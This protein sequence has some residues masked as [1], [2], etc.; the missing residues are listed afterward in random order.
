MI[1]PADPTL[2]AA[3]P[4]P[5]AV[6]IHPLIAARWSPRA[7]AGRPVER[8]KLQAVFEAARWAPSSFN[9]QPWRFLVATVDQPEW[10]E[11]LKG[12]LTPGNADWAGRAPVLVAS[13]YKTHFSQNDKPNRVAFRDLG[14]AEE[15]LFLQAFAE[16]LVMHQMGGFDAERLEE[17]L[18]PEGFRAGTMFAIGYAGDPGVLNEKQQEREKQPRERKELSE[19]IFAGKWG[20]PAMPE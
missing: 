12:Y 17:E 9:E 14:A 20:E 16:G 11:R 8:A 10:L 1:P 5:T 18:L 13:A 7:F 19:L 4:A 3:R 15:N 2:E 6:S